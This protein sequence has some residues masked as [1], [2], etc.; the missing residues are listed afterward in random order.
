[1]GDYEETALNLLLLGRTQSGKSAT[2]N[3]LLGSYEFQSEL[4]FRSVT[5]DCRLCTILVDNLMRR[6]GKK[7]RLEVKVLDT[8]GYPNSKFNK[9]IIKESIQKALSQNFKHG[10]HFA[11]IVLKADSPL[12]EEDNQIAQLVKGILG[13]EW[14]DFTAVVITHRDIVE[15]AHYNEDK[16]LQTATEPLQRLLAFVQNRFHFVNNSPDCLKNEQGPLLQK[17]MGFVRQNNYKV[18][19]FN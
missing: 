4:S 11:I 14:N 1:M 8:P 16:Y 18:L 10:L 13:P 9:D 2:G 6:N 3:C 15:R 5:E 19:K 7:L 17:L 12:C